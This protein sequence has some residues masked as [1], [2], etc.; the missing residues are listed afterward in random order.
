MILKELP[1]QDGSHETEKSEKG[2]TKAQKDK[3]NIN[4]G[5][6]VPDSGGVVF[7]LLMVDWIFSLAIGVKHFTGLVQKLRG[8]NLCSTDW[9]NSCCMPSRCGGYRKSHF[10]KS[11]VETR[12]FSLFFANRA[13]VRAE[14][15]QG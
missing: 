15:R 12:F 4:S 5:Q 13:E 2:F 10:E 6:E 14:F 8:C 9:C 3:R 7:V 1:K 11:I